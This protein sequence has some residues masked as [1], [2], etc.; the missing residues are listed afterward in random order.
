MCCQR[1]NVVSHPKCAVDP[2]PTGRG[3]DDHDSSATWVCRACSHEVDSISHTASCKQC[4]KFDYIFE[5][6][7]QKVDL[8]RMLAP[9]Q[10]EDEGAKRTSNVK[11]YAAELVQLRSS[12]EQYRAH[13]IHTKAQA[14]LKYDCLELLA[15]DDTAWYSLADYWA[16]LT[17][18][19]SKEGNCE[20]TQA[21][22]SCH[23][24]TFYYKKPSF[25]KR[26]EYI[27]K[28]LVGKDYFEGFPNPNERHF[29]CEN[30]QVSI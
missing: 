6:I 20:G 13:L 3:D 9:N 27:E 25:P 12:L 10:G 17:P 18:R 19:K 4:N 29:V 28:K 2:P 23:G 8:L 11:T 22:I 7:K 15:K 5:D 14:Y 30:Y 16:K 24:T 1:C 21:G 26:A